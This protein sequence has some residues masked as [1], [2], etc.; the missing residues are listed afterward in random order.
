MNKIIEKIP[1]SWEEVTI[2]DYEA[3]SEISIT[4]NSEADNLFVGI[5]NT[6]KVL[7]Y[8]TETSIEELEKLPMTEITSMSKRLDFMMQ[9]VKTEKKSKI[10]WKKVEEITYNDFI[11]YQQF[12]ADFFKNL[13][14]LI[15][16]F[17]KEKISEEEVLNLSVVDM[18]TAFFFLKKLAEKSLKRTAFYLKADQ[19][20]GKIAAKI[21]KLVY[22]LKWKKKKQ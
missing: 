12:S 15:P 19:I 14:L 20:N 13:H 5:D 8:F 2:R 3:L 10:K 18:T 9:P 4:E 16:A 21:L 6:L 22:K 1:T 7:S 17:S 11:L